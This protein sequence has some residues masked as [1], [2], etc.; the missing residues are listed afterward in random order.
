MASDF[1]LMIRGRGIT[2]L[3]RIAQEH[4][5]P[6]WRAGLRVEIVGDRLVARHPSGGKLPNT[7]RVR[8]TLSQDDGNTHIDG[9]AD[10][11][12]TRFV[13]ALYVGLAVVFLVLAAVILIAEGP[14]NPGF[15]V[16][17]PSGALFLLVGVANARAGSP[18]LDAMILE[19][20]LTRL[21]GS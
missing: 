17:A 18:D 20:D 12:G 6:W 14:A 7:P 16:C 11:P 9:R 13:V 10:N 2:D 5:T 21:F 15:A 1:H 8:A 4:H 3:S 19:G